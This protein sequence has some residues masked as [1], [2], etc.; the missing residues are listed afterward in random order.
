MTLD[1][2]TQKLGGET[3]PRLDADNTGL[4]AVQMLDAIQTVVNVLTDNDGGKGWSVSYDPTLNA[5]TD[6]SAAR[7][8]V[9]SVKPLLDAKPGDPLTGVAAIMT[10]F[11]VHEIGHTKLNFYDAISKRWPGKDLP[12]VLGNIIEDVVLEMR[13]VE[14]FPGFADHGEGNVFR[15]TLEWVAKLTSPKTPLA[16]KGSTGHK[17]NVVGQIV[18]YREFVT[19]TDE[20]M[21]HVEWVERWAEGITPQLTPSG[22]VALISD[23]LDYMKASLEDETPEPP[24]P[25]ID[26]PEPPVGTGGQTIP[27]EDDDDEPPTEGGDDGEPG[28]GDGDG[29]GGGNG[30]ADDEDDDSDDDDSDGGSTEGDDDEDEDGEG[31]PFESDPDD[32][33]DGGSTDGGSEDGPG[34]DGDGNDADTLNRTEGGDGV[35]D[36]P[37]SGGTGQSVADSKGEDLDAADLD[38][39]KSEVADSFDDLSKPEGYE[40]HRISDAEQEERV[41]TRVDAGA[42]GK[43]RVIFR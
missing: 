41:T 36:G 35:N 5:Y 15:P 18:R 13:T 16:W 38:F 11:A 23:L 20:A 8:I 4:V 33:E 10:G 37:G 24:V 43:M 27:N 40:Q 21:P 6:R 42:F 17:V 29:D 12:K 14:R 22:C 26:L 31:E 9:V 25:P 32:D 3:M 30:E 2:F 7:R 39:D 1:V 19:F 34:R 28:D